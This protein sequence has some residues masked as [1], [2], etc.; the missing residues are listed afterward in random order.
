MKFEKIYSCTI[1]TF[2]RTCQV[3]YWIL[4]RDSWIFPTMQHFKRKCWHTTPFF[5]Y[6]THPKTNSHCKKL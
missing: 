5:I 1:S 3:R 6:S 4:L 2:Y